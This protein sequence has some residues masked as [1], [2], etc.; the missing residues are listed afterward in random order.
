MEG[1]KWPFFLLVSTPP[2][3]PSQ[4][5]TTTSQESDSP[6]LENTLLNDNSLY[7]LTPSFTYSYLSQSTIFLPIDLTFPTLYSYD[8]STPIIHQQ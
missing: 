3:S 1:Y 7:E 6:P 4:E 2:K 8:S 5:S